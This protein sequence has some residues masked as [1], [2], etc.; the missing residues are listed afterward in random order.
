MSLRAHVGIFRSERRDTRITG[1]I[2]LNPFEKSISV[3]TAE[4]AVY[5]SVI[6][7]DRVFGAAIN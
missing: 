3:A 5:K 2:R 1:D 4:L 6:L 7:R